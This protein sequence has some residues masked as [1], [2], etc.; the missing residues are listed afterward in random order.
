M[1]PAPMEERERNIVFSV[2][3]ETEY[4]SPGR[5]NLD[6]VLVCCPSL[7]LE[8]MGAS[9]QMTQGLSE[10]RRNETKLAMAWSEKREE[11]RDLF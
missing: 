1:A 3:R 10:H 9:V 2:I 11:R 7:W 4:V 5:G 8:T 6:E